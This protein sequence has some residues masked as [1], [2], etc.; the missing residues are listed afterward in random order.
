M[1]R[2]L[3]YQNIS[4]YMQLKNVDIEISG[5]N[6]MVH[7]IETSCGQ[8]LAFLCLKWILGNYTLCYHTILGSNLGFSLPNFDY[9]L[10]IAVVGFKNIKEH[11]TLLKWSP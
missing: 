4:A 2:Y 3:M 7:L 5:H 9:D 1:I 10:W 8:R 11:A 6:N